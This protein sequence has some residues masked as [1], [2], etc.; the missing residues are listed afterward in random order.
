MAQTTSWSNGGLTL[1]DLAALS[2]QPHGEFEAGEKTV[3]EPA[4]CVGTSKW[5]PTAG[6]T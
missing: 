5:P 6:G 4:R 1:N 3:S 2:Q